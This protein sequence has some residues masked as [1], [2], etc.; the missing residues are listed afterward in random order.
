MK[1][2]I[3]TLYFSPSGTTKKISLLLAKHLENKLT[4]YER[5]NDKDFTL[6]D[7]RSKE[8]VYKASDLVVV[9]LPVYAGRLPNILLTY[10]KTLQGN[11]ALAVVLVV[12]GNRDYDDA[13]IELADLLLERGFKVIAGVAFIGQHA[14][15]NT[16]GLNRPDHSDL[17]MI[18]EY[19]GKIVEKIN[20][21]L[22]ELLEIKGER[23]YRPYYRPKDEKGLVVNFK[24]IKPITLESCIGCNICVESCPVGSIDCDDVSHIKG[25]CLKCC[26]CVNRC[27]VKAKVFINPDFIR[28]KLELETTYKNRKEPDL[29]L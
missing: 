26:S 13:L 9:G 21:G 29:F 12:Y 17:Y 28:H 5:S 23:P 25:M 16:L 15:S 3:K 6:L 1:N 10:L 20:R 4:T 24:S 11:G 14:F 22:L 19:S 27:P 18:E 7:S 2:K 8:M